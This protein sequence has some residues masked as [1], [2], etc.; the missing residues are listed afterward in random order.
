M[1]YRGA[2]FLLGSFTSKRFLVEEYW[3]LLS[4]MLFLLGLF[5]DIHLSCKIILYN[6]GYYSIHMVKYS[7]TIHPWSLESLAFQSLF[8]NISQSP[9]QLLDELTAKSG[10]FHHSEI[11]PYTQKP[12]LMK[13][14]QRAK[15][16]LV[17]I[18]RR[19]LNM[20]LRS[21][22]SPPWLSIWNASFPS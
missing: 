3:N 11:T 7:T 13:N 20:G 5:P 16:P 4:N 18:A 21:N 14:F 6:D 15:G 2:F 9:P 8:S 1:L 12:Y 19:P 10:H 17:H 22:P